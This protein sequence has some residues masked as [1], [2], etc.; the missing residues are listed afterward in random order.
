M[1]D[2]VKRKPWK[3]M[4]SAERR[5][6]T[7]FLKVESEARRLAREEQW[8]AQV[9]SHFGYL[10]TEYGFHL[11]EANAKSGWETFVRYESSFLAVKV[12]RSVEFNS[13]ELWLIRLVNGRVPEYP[14]F[15]YPDTPI[16]YVMLDT[17][18]SRRSP[19]AA[20]PFHSLRGLSEEEIERTLMFLATAL[21]AYA[22][23]VLRGDF[24]ILDAIADERHDYARQH[25]PQIKI[26]MPATTPPEDVQRALDHQRKADPQLSA[27]VEMYDASASLLRRKRGRAAKPAPAED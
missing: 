14:V 4:T 19:E 9:A 26:W 23:D 10:E 27:S 3:Q 17:V 8:K 13:A 7:T 2:P 15:I 20:A 21:R 1:S 12:A 24:A 11:A 25:P 18:V 22:D 16:N 5:A 6:R